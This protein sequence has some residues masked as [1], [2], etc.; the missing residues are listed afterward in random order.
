[1]NMNTWSS[2]SFL[3]MGVLMI[4]GLPA[5]STADKKHA[6]DQSF[7]NRGI[8]VERS[9]EHHGGIYSVKEIAYG[10]DRGTADRGTKGASG[11]LA[12]ADETY[13]LRATYADIKEKLASIGQRAVEPSDI[14]GSGD[15]SQNVYAE[16]R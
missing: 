11:D 16:A 6:E 2:L 8:L 4:M 15:L 10:A 14:D 7:T 9:T 1:M 12:D 3:F 13:G 5:L